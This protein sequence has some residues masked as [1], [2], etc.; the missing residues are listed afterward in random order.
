MTMTDELSARAI[1]ERHM[2]ES[3]EY[4]REY[5]RARFANEVAVRV[6]K[7]RAEHG[8]SQTALAKLLGMH[9]PAIARLE[10][11]EHEPSLT[12]LARLAQVL[13]E[14][15]SVDI[16]PDRIELRSTGLS[17]ARTLSP[18]RCAAVA[19]RRGRCAGCTPRSRGCT[20]S[21]A[22]A[23]GHALRQAHRPA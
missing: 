8:L 11:G 15:F 7:Y 5:D 16:K 19:G 3:L 4:R 1:H 20:P 13:G 14:D 12:T 21:A 10:A 17:C 23:C 18:R 2:R 6:V 9:Q 22:T